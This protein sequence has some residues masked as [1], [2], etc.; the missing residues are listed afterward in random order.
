[1]DG[2]GN[3]FLAG[4]GFAENQNSSV[5]ISDLFHLEKNILNGGT[6]A[7]DT[8]KIVLKLDFL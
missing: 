1:M 3:Q 7:D 8:L 5:G 4:H 2:P 6:V